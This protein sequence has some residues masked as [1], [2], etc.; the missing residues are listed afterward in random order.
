M[1]DWARLAALHA[2]AFPGDRGWTAGE[3]ES[4][5]RAGLLIEA[6]DGFA[7][8]SRAAD[9]AELLTIAVAP[10]ARRKGRARALLTAGEIRLAGAGAARV[11]LEVAEDNA[12]A[13]AL[14]AAAGYREIARRPAYYRRAEGKVDALLLEKVLA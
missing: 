13:R 1:T 4:L 12:A 10:D 5:A 14:Y 2:A 6:E 11:F 8:F 3:I 7:L 9:E